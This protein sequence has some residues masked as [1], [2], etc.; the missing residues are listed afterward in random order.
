MP[1]QYD[2]I[3]ISFWKKRIFFI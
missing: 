3:W 1:V 2:K